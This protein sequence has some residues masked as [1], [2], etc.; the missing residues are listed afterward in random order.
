MVLGTQKLDM[1]RFGFAESRLHVTAYITSGWNTCCIDKS[2]STE[3]S[4]AINSMYR[5][6]R[7]AAKCYVTLADVST[8][9]FETDLSFQ[10]W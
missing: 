4:E 6:Y 2:N 1:K 7:K 3:L 5:W 10:S 9:G 8:S